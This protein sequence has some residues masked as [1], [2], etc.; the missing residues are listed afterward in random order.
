MGAWEREQMGTALVMGE[1]VEN[2]WQPARG[3]DV[4]VKGT[5]KEKNPA[6]EM[7]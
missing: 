1:K 3:K 6:R 7:E 5:Q 4:R 2:Q